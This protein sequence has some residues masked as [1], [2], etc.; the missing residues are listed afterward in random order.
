LGTIAIAQI[1]SARQQLR[2]IGSRGGPA[3]TD[4]VAAPDA[5]RTS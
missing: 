5:S 2:Q 3:L 1:L 4:A